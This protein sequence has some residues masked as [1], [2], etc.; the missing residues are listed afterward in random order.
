M[1]TLREVEGQGRAVE[2]LRRALENNRLH[3]AFLFAGPDG[4]GK[5]LTAWALAGALLCE[6]P[7]P[8]AD[9]CGVC[10]ACARVAS[11]DHPDLHLVERELKPDGTPEGQIK[12]AQ[13]RE[14]QRKL[15]FKSFE[16]ARRVALVLEPERMN[17]STANALLKTLEEPG[18]G[19][20]FVLVTAEANRLLPTII[21]RCQWVRFAPLPRALVAAKVAE[22][23][24]VEPAV[25]D[26]LAGL[27]E[28]SIG[29]ARQ[30]ADSPW[31]AERAAL[32]ERVDDPQALHQVPALLDLADRLARVKDEL[33]LVF[34]L[35]RTWYRDVLMAHTGRPADALVHRDLA[36]QVDARAQTLSAPGAMARIDALNQ[37]EYD[38]LSRQAN[39][40]LFLEG[41]F[42]KLANPR[43][44][45]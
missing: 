35:L 28:G 16:G 43:F 7:R 21:S 23:A 31:L 17:D 38:I 30:L 8:D 15:S 9:A 19:T 6:A 14:L 1:T 36:A 18:P 32:I 40:R 4:V 29:K 33:P 44:G 3:H 13:V 25:A 41:L 24:G 27:G 42:L 39:A 5:R 45:A 20:H 11:G 2:A 22:Q 37:A 26:L 12:I 10:R 34:H